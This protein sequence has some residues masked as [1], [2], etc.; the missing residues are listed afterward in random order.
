MKTFFQIL[1]LCFSNVVVCGQNF[2]ITTISHR[3]GEALAYSANSQFLAVGAP[4]KV[5]IYNALTGKKI[6][7]LEGINGSVYAVAFSPDNEH[8]AAVSSLG[9][10]TVW[11]IEGDILLDRI[12]LAG[13]GYGIAFLHDNHLVLLDQENLG[14]YDINKKNWGLKI[15]HAIPEPRVLTV[16]RDMIAI[17]GSTKS[18]H[19]LGMDGKEKFQLKGHSDWIRSLDFHPNEPVLASGSDNGEVILWNLES[20]AKS[21]S[22]NDVKGRIYGLKFSSDASALI[23]GGKSVL[24]WSLEK[25]IALYESKRI[26]TELIGLAITSDGKF[27]ATLEDQIPNISFTDLTSLEFAPAF[28]LKDEKDNTPPQIYVSNP[29]NIRDDRVLLMSDLLQ[30]KGSV[31]DDTGIQSLKIN[32]IETPIKNKANFLINIPLTIGENQITIEAKDLN[33]N[34]AMRKFIVDR[35][36]MD[37]SEYDPSKARNYLLAIAIDNYK[38]ITKLNNPVK[39]VSDIVKTLMLNYNFEFEDVTF[40][41]NESA[42]RAN[43]LESMRGLIEKLTPQDNLIIYF[44]GHGYFDKLMN[45]G[46]WVPVEAQNTF[47]DFIPNSMI[48]KILENIDTQHIFLVADACFSGSLF[49]ATTRGYVENVEK[50]RSRW[51]LTSGRLELVADGEKGQNSP[52]AKH[53]LDFLIRNNNR[54]FAVSELV[55]YVKI[56][57]AEDTSQTPLGN[58]LKSIGDEGGEFIFYHRN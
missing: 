24:I 28:L 13:K 52:F 34:I 22:F 2:P 55:Q 41:K 21:I 51:G 15:K 29:A 54:N 7:E 37:G 50:F 14:F 16:G 42:T 20:K 49:A 57:T 18:I 1:V 3:Y 12:E 44:A 6:L 23:I 5:F 36:N 9:S 46:Y 45:E 47:N 30:V 58:P 39:D 31:F 40:L 27:M 38:N 26:R 33:G 35:K 8:I 25:K 10:A 19:I 43:I 11:N 48:L 53:F 56:R 17:G 4:D 32:G